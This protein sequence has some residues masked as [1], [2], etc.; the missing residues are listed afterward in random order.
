MLLAI[1]LGGALSGCV[2]GQRFVPGFAPTAEPLTASAAVGLYD[3]ARDA[4]LRL[5]VAGLDEDALGEPSRA[6]ASYQR[7]IRVDPTNPFAFLAL[8]RHHLE[9]GS[10]D[11]ASAF[12]DQA[13]SLFEAEQTLGPSVDVWGLGLR[14][15]IERGR[16]QDDRA[17]A[18]FDRARALSP[19]IW[20]DER[21]SAAELR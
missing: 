4:S 7:A 14:A 2:A 21:L 18:L 9:D 5:V 19:S 15:G 1:V 16:G 11:E 3:S 17:D 12:L 13:R 8:A 10:L 6:L 20:G